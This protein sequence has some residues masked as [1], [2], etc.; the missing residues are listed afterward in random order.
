MV[1]NRPVLLVRAEEVIIRWYDALIQFLNR[2][3][4]SNVTLDELTLPLA[5]NWVGHLTEDDFR[6]YSSA[7]GVAAKTFPAAG[8]VIAL[9]E[10]ARSH[11][12]VAYTEA[13]EAG[14]GHIHALIRS[15]LRNS[16][17][18][19][20]DIPVYG[21]SAADT[22]ANIDRLAEFVGAKVVIDHDHLVIGHLLR[23]RREIS[24]FLLAC[25]WNRYH[26]LRVPVNRLSWPDITNELLVNSLLSAQAS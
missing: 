12:I 19:N 16:S 11:D 6:T 20:V 25:P 8:V 17:I 3:S 26:G 15:V 9:P 24:C 14:C 22:P 2:V 21:V 10:L 5:T 23:Q 7:Y 4:G 1:S 13:D 18:G